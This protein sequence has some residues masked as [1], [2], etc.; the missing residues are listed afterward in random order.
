MKA[1]AAPLTSI[2]RSGRHSRVRRLRPILVIALLLSF[3]APG[4]VALGLELHLSLHLSRAHD[5]G[6]GHDGE[7]EGFGWVPVHG[8]HHAADDPEHGHPALVTRT[9]RAADARP[10]DR[11]APAPPV[12]APMDRDLGRSSLPIS[13]ARAGPDLR[14]LLRVAGCGPP[15]TLLSAS[16]SLLL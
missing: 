1:R 4:M 12:V 15:D 10:V 6:H 16:C 11:G 5:H 3:L 9:L 7:S 13:Y 2:D 14:R 8:H